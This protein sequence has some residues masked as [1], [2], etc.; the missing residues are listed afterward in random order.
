M[1]NPGL[2]LLLGSMPW[3]VGCANG[4][5]SLPYDAWY[6]GFLARNYMEVWIETADAVDV[7]DHVFRRAMSGV[8]AIN[9]PKDLKG[10][11]SG[12]PAYPG[13]GKGKHVRGADL[14]RLIYVRWQSLV[15][16]QTYEAYIPIPESTRQAMVKGEKTYCD[17]DGKWITDY[18]Y[19]L[20]IGLAPGGVT[21]TWI[22]GPCLLPIEVTRVEGTVVK[23]GPYGGTSSGRHRPLSDT[24]KAYVEKY[25]IPY[26][27]W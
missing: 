27:S 11:P 22:S 20:T 26:G 13:M 10:N 24:S 4:T 15:E 23:E 14:P 17:F 2:L 12:W 21:K 7:N 9:T 25:G 19:M 6:L 18:R 3:L 8:A 1:S 16:P 5:N